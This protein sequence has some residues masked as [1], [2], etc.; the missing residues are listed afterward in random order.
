MTDALKLWDTYVVLGS[1]GGVYE[2]KR[3]RETGPQLPARPLLG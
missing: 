3:T 2:I 1:I